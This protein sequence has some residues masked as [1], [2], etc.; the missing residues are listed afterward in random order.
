MSKR[1]FKDENLQALFDKQGFVVVPFIDSDEVKMLTDLFY[2]LHPNLQ[3]AGFVS[4][5]YSHDY[6]YKKKAS[7]AFIN[8]FTKHYERIFINYQPFGGAYLYKMPASASEL[9]I[10]QDWTIV[11]ENKY[12]ALNC[13]VPL[14][15]IDETNGGL[16]V[17]PGSQYDALHTVRAPTLPFFFSGNDDVVVKASVPMYVKAGTA[18]ILNESVIHYSPP[19][20]SDKLRLAITAGVKSKGAPM[21]FHYFDKSQPNTNRLEVFDMPED[22]LISFDN[23]YT[24]IFERPK[25]GVGKGFIDYQMPSFTREALIETIATMKKN[26]GFAEHTAGSI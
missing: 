5:S 8:A 9:A 11:D 6:A 15:D 1:I 26:A 10:H 21:Q 12:V 24:D 18:V 20:Q 7:D 22:F 4:G 25:K 17:V 3:G 19:N 2:E 14:T 23:F 16:H 13:W